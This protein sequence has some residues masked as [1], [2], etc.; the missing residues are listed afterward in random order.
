ME[1]VKKICGK[2]EKIEGKVWKFIDKNKIW[3]FL[4]I[5]TVL[6]IILR[7][8]MYSNTYGD[9]EMFIDP[10]FNQLKACGRF[11]SSLL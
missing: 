8:N 4:I 11:I 5:I 10:W 3:I 9:F 6:A 1:T 2:I 7:S